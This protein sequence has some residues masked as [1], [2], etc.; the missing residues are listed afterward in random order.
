MAIK[1]L[2][3]REV[4]KSKGVVTIVTAADIPGK[5]FEFGQ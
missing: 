4:W 2:D 3:L 1:K 5:T